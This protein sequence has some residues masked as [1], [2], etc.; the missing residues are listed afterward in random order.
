AR[1]DLR[2]RRR[3]RRRPHPPIDFA[4]ETNRA[5]LQPMHVGK[6]L[7][8]AAEPTAHADACIAAHEWLYAEGFVEFI[9]KRL[10]ASG[11]DPRHMFV[12]RKSERYRGEKRRCRHLALPVE[13]G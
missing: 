3:L 1:Q 13:R 6:A 4:A 11:V 9:P 5:Q 10:P 8:F 2:R 12:R 7:D